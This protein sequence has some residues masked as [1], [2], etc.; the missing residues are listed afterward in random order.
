M[1]HRCWLET[2]LK[3]C[4]LLVLRSKRYAEF[5]AVSS[6]SIARPSQA[7]H[8]Q[9]RGMSH[10]LYTIAREEVR[11]CP[12]WP[13]SGPVSRVL[14]SLKVGC[15]WLWVKCREFAHYSK[16]QRPRSRLRFHAPP[17]VCF[18][19]SGASGCSRRRLHKR[20]ATSTICHVC[21]MFKIMHRDV[22]S[23]RSSVSA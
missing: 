16:G 22:W 1:T 15:G 8:F 20:S 17:S 11:R 23:W 14:W 6:R 21:C 10:G 18:S 2:I 5:V 12:P 13:W 19:S 3:M 9:Y 7:F 4:Y